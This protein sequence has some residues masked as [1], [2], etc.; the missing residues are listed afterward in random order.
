MSRESIPSHP[1]FPA[2]GDEPPPR[3]ERFHVTRDEGQ[4]RPVYHARM[5][6][7]NE[8]QDLA[9]LRQMFGGGAYELVAYAG[10]RISARRRY[11]I[12]GRKKPMNEPE[13][14]EQDAAALLPA[15]P[16]LPT[17]TVG[18]G[19]LDV[20]TL[21]LLFK[22]MSDQQSSSLQVMGQVMSAAM[23]RPEAPRNDGFDRVLQVMQ[24]QQAQQFELL[25]RVMTAGGSQNPTSAMLDLVRQG[26]E[27][28]RKSAGAD[29]NGEGEED[30]VQSVV[31]A[32]SQVGA[33]F[34]MAAQ[35]ERDAAGAPQVGPG[36][37]AGPPP[38]PQSEEQAAE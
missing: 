17:G 11:W 10:G 19:G 13:A 3:V 7:P 12:D 31:Q 24:A 4:G 18:G 14:A 38:V 20:Q 26:I 15:L 37:I 29:G 35:A 30:F 25:A 22:M 1:L 23:A 8:L 5:F 27:L 34:Q 2:Q 16:T 32:I 9:E 21:F 28:G 6:G 36:P 33:G